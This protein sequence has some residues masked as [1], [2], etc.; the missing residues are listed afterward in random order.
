MPAQ[1]PNPP[2]FTS[3]EVDVCQ[4]NTHVLKVLVCGQWENVYKFIYIYKTY[5]LF[6][7]PKWGGMIGVTNPHYFRNGVGAPSPLK[8]NCK[9]E[10]W[11]Y[12][13]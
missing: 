8:K 2:N 9:D 12:V 10:P 5:I 1:H 3:N 4:Q 7:H 11:V 13:D 6:L